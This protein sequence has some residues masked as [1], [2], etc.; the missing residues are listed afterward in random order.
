MALSTLTSGLDSFQRG[1]Y[2]GVGHSLGVVL[3]CPIFLTLEYITS[4][5]VS[6]ETWEYYGD[7]FI[8]TSMVAVASYFIC[9]EDVYL[10]KHED[11][12]YMAKGCGCHSGSAPPCATND[13]KS[14]SCETQSIPEPFLECPTIDE[15]GCNTCSLEDSTKQMKP[16]LEGDDSTWTLHFA[17]NSVLGFFQGLCCPVGMTVG[18]GFISR[19]TATASAPM[20]VAFVLEFAFASGVGAGMIAIGWGILTRTGSQSCISG[21]VLYIAT[22][23]MLL[24]FGIAWLVAHSLGVLD[25]IDFEDRIHDKLM[26]SAF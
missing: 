21:R 6:R 16:E 20:L 10:Q 4:S 1:F 17:R 24:L 25:R 8:G 23:T 2:W 22:C 5:K 19:V 3:L 12:T 18:T 13:S 26:P 9:H 15:D 11:G 14:A 7:I